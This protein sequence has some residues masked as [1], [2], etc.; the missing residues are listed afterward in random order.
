MTSLLPLKTLLPAGM[1]MAT[2]C[3]APFGSATAHIGHVGEVAGH[4]HLVGIGLI[5]ASAVLTGWLATREYDGERTVQ[6]DADEAEAGD[7]V[8]A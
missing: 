6:D 5:A 3:I 8:N 4:G 1:V 7:E 2:T